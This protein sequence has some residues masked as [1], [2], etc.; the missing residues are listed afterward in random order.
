MADSISSRNVQRRTRPHGV[1][2]PRNCL[3]LKSILAPAMIY[4]RFGP[5]SD[6]MRD[7]N[8]GV[9]GSPLNKLL[10]IVSAK[11]ENEDVPRPRSI[12]ITD[13][14]LKNSC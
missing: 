8:N 6:Q 1:D 9:K 10:A 4:T 7:S 5:N 11:T 3:P 12:L 14:R 2:S 13:L